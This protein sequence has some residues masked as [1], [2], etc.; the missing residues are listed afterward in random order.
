[1]GVHFFTGFPGFIATELIKGLIAEGNAEKFYALVL[2]EQTNLRRV[3]AALI[4]EEMETDVSLEIVSGDIT[5]P[6]LGM[7]EH[8]ITAL[9]G[10]R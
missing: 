5:K 6:N 3:K 9:R 8:T 2:P 4:M 7:N 10:N 1:M